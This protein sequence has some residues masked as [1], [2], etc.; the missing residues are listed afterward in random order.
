MSYENFIETSAEVGE[1]GALS[2]EI[3]AVENE[4]G[5]LGGG[6]WRRK[7][8]RVRKGLARRVAGGLAR[9]GLSPAELRGKV[10]VP[11]VIYSGRV[12]PTT[13]AHGT[14]L[15]FWHYGIGD[16]AVANANYTAVGTD[17][18][19]TYR[20]TNLAQGGKIHQDEIF[21]LFG[22]SFSIYTDAAV[23]S[24]TVTD[25]LDVDPINLARWGNSLQ[26]SYQEKQ[27]AVN[28]TRGPLMTFP[29]AFGPT[30]SYANGTLSSTTYAGHISGRP[31]V[32]RKPLTVIRGNLAVADMPRIQLT[33]NTMPT[34]TTLVQ[35][36]TKSHE[37][38]CYGHGIALKH[39]SRA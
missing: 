10:I 29:R 26:V 9:Y 39:P 25:G 38:I 8:L 20:Q 28:I 4:V 12:L 34:Q 36:G 13:M 16:D 27:G 1:L 19:A 2:A 23:T 37:I 30:A 17:K 24:T 31:N 14:V 3:E 22:V 33:A 15:N 6:A 35:V 21:I 18:G 7:L 32:Q 11:S 5:D